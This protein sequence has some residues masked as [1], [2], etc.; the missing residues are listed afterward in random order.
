MQKP[1]GSRK[2]FTQPNEAE[3]AEFISLIQDILPISDVQQLKSYYQHCKTTR[4]QHCINVAYYTYLMSKKMKLNYR[5]ATRGA[6]LHDFYLY[7]WKQDEQPIDGR[8]SQVHPQ[9]ALEMAKQTL[10]VDAIMEDCILNHMWPM[11]KNHPVTKEG[12]V[13]QGADKLCAVME[14]STQSAKRCN[15]KRLRPLFTT[16]SAYIK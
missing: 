7:D 15:P 9:V 12:W 16:I 5:S 4:F 10:S 14:I 1:I 3:V 11:T 8:H 6:L 13:V 2:N